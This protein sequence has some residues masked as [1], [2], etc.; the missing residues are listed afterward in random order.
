MG[1]DNK[2]VILTFVTLKLGSKKITSSMLDQI[3]RLDFCELLLDE[4]DCFDCSPNIVPVARFSIVSLLNSQRRVYKAKGYDSDYTRRLIKHYAHHEEAFLF[5]YKGQLYCDS[6]S[7]KT[8]TQEYGNQLIKLRQ[9]LDE[10]DSRL[11]SVNRVLDLE[12]QG[13]E[14]HDIARK[15]SKGQISLPR[16]RNRKR[17]R[18]ILD[19][20]D[21]DVLG[22]GES[23]EKIASHEIDVIMKNHGSW[24]AYIK[25]IKQE[26][27]ME[28]INK[29]KFVSDVENFN[30]KVS[31]VINE[32]ISSPFT[33]FGC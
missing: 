18:N 6:F 27:K 28:Q 1:I 29:T 14:A 24:D 25:A 26:V 9:K 13:F 31:T 22:F 32:I 7:S 8:G 3:P 20:W 19:D 15:C 2:Q 10:C 11:A 12:E 21:D 23:D 17:V 30:E 16:G 5:T 33:L 4:D